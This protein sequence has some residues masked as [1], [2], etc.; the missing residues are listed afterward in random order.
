MDTSADGNYFPALRKRSQSHDPFDNNNEQYVKTSFVDNACQRRVSRR[1]TARQNENQYLKV[2]EISDSSVKSQVL[3]V[4]NDM[5]LRNKA[6]HT[7]WC[8]GS[9]TETSCVM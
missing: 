6:K 7:W 8:Q 4:T 1:V 5:I 3:P 9:L 2:P